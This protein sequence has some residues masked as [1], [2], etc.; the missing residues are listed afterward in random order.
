MTEN[1]AD[2]TAPGIEMEEAHRV[3]EILQTRLHALN[4]LHLTLKHAHWNVVGPEF[5]SVHE[6]LDPQV[7]QVRGWADLVAERIATMG[8]SPK[9]TPG[10]IVTG[11]T[12]ED[13]PLGRASSLAHITALNEVYTDVIKD[14]RTAIAESAKVDP[15]SEDVLIEITRG[16]ELFQWFL[17]SFITKADGSLEPVTE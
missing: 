2:Y 7:D 17:R 5:I 1:Y 12:W 8:V 4:D 14:F 11:R 16:L 15:I 10:A 13:Y 3:T 9:G 6:M